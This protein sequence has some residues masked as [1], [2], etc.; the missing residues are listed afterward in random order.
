MRAA[1]PKILIA[2][3]GSL[4]DLH[5]FIALGQALQREGFAIVVATSSEHREAVESAGLGFTAI[6][7]SAQEVTERLG[8]D[9]G[10]LARRMS[11][12]DGFLFKDVIFPHLREAFDQFLAASEDAVA[13]VAHSIAFAAQAAAEKRGLPLVVVTLSPVLLY[14]AHDP[15][16]AS[17]LPFVPGP[18]GRLALAY[19]RALLGLLG[20]FAQFWAAPLTGFRRDLGLP[21]RGPF[22]L[23]HGPAPGVATIALHSPTLLHAEP[24]Q[25]RHVLVAGHSFHDSNAPMEESEAEALEAFLSQGPAPVVFTLGSFVAHGHE[26]HYRACMEACAAL[27]V[28]AVL[29]AHAEDVAR[30]RAAAPAELHV[31]PYV[32]HSLLFPRALVVAHHGGIGTSGQALRAGKPQLVTPFLGDQ[33]DNAAR[34]RRLGVARTLAGRAINPLRLAR[35]LRALLETPDYALR[36]RELGAVVSQEDGASAAAHRI[37]ELLRVS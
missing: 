8:T 17:G 26:E 16:F 13:I 34:L 5:P 21:A 27:G 15:P 18:R 30:L 4:G 2:T 31:A 35:E 10:G 6:K 9:F 33:Q 25:G 14:S 23:F 19:N 7:P 36:A 24:H 32:P 3:F 1:L 22:A 12:N 11:E 29:L 37:A 20:R 28:R